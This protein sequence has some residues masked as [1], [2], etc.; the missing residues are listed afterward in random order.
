M[1]KAEPGQRFEFKKEGLVVTL[2]EDVW[3]VVLF[4]VL[5]GGAGIFKRLSHGENVFHP[6][7]TF[8]RT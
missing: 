1:K 2:W 5:R 7:F 6:D 4:R 8:D 3:L